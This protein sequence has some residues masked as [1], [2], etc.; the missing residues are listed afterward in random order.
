LPQSLRRL[1]LAG[2]VVWSRSALRRMACYLCEDSGYL[3]ASGPCATSEPHN[4]NIAG[5]M[6]SSESLSLCPRVAATQ[7]LCGTLHRTPGGS[8]SRPIFVGGWPRCSP[9]RPGTL[10]TAIASALYTPAEAQCEPFSRDTVPFWPA[11]SSNGPLIRR[12]VPN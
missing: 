9:T 11:A 7:P 2:P 4:P 1:R 12:I 8:P 3:D 5:V 10:T 6:R